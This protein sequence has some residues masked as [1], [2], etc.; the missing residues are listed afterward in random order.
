MKGE[1]IGELEELVLLSVGSLGNE[2]Y[3]VNIL[4][5]IKDQAARSIDVTAVHAV[6]R[7][8]DKK[9]FVTSR[10]G[11]ATAERGGRRK[12]LFTLTVAG[13]KVLDNSMVV[14]MEMYKKLLTAQGS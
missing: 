6:L 9:G 7:R 11:G 10:M 4:N 12:R 13:R 5:E 8:L 1:S 14:R 3:A 2:A